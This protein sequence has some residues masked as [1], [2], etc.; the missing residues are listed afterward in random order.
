MLA[1]I[2]TFAEDNPPRESFDIHL[3]FTRGL[4][5]FRKNVRSG[6]LRKAAVQECGAQTA[7]L[8]LFRGAPLNHASWSQ[9][10]PAS[11]ASRA[12]SA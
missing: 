9:H 12:G 3:A 1:E 5:S 10:R 2:A 11:G 4:A 7:A 8:V 6:A